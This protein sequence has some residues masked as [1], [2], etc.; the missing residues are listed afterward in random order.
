MDPLNAKPRSYVPITTGFHP[1]LISRHPEQEGISVGSAVTQWQGLNL[2]S[3]DHSWTV[4]S[5]E[6][7]VSPGSCSGNYFQRGVI[8]I[9]WCSVLEFGGV[10]YQL[11]VSS[12]FTS[13]LAR[14][15]DL[16]IDPPYYLHVSE[17]VK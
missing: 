13:S 8:L 9:F 15:S 2:E 3:E 4:D 6:D 12:L 5:I 16:K 10:G 17:L 11:R 7:R 1:Y 14:D